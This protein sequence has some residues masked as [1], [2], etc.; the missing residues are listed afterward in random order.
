[1]TALAG[2]VADYLALRRS[3][4]YKLERAGLLLAQ[5]V[6][7]CDRHSV[8]T[9]TVEVAV[10]WATA[11]VGAGV[12]WWSRRLSV[13][14]G[15]AIYLHTLD[16]AAEVPPADLLPAP[17]P[18]A[19]PYIYSDADLRG[20]ID[21]TI[22]LR[23]PLRVATYQNL[24]GLL[25]VTG[26]RVGEAIRLDTADLDLSAGTVTIWHTKF[27]KSR[28]NH[29]DPTA[30]TA[31]S[32]YV[33]RRR[34]HLAV[35]AQTSLALFLSPAGTRLLASNVENTFRLL[36]ARAG[37]RPRSAA[38]RPRMHDIRHTFAVRTLLDAYTAGG[39]VGGVLPLLSTWMGHVNPAATYWY[40]TAVPELLAVANDRLE[41]H[42]GA[43]Q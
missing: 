43:P 17:I 12:W 10:A 41:E 38:C 15:F 2:H 14:R 8:E 29:L 40:L 25:A 18:R 4:G 28:R 7:H 42:L 35:R 31:L 20:L 32:A 33:E 23:H 36:V 26:M 21:A 1:M 24:L 39:D 22:T 34:Q 30:I 9:V 5:F 19:T 37:L 13:V 16:P 6:E 3:L 27:D 11:P